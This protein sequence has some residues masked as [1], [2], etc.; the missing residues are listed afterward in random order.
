[1]RVR[2]RVE[3]VFVE[4]ANVHFSRS[5]DN[6]A[7]PSIIK[8]YFYMISLMQ[9]IVR[10]M[11]VTLRVLLPLWFAFV[12]LIVIIF[13]NEIRVEMNRFPKE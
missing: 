7:I 8:S 6:A 10:L 9:S 4:N 5:L 1:M 2:T 11:A 3:R 12:A 13:I